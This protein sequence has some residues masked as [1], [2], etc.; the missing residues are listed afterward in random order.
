MGV[1]RVS[2]NGGKK[3]KKPI[4][5]LRLV[6][7]LLFWEWPHPSRATS[8]I[9]TVGHRQKFKP[10]NQRNSKRAQILLNLAL[11]MDL[12]YMTTKLN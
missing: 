11:K 4:H 6:L 2:L 7:S 1:A 5:F 9:P 10:I 12:S 8:I 3:H